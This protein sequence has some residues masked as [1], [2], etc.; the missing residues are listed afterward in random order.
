MVALPPFRRRMMNYLIRNSPYA[1]RRFAAFVVV[2]AMT[3]P[4]LAQT[5]VKRGFN[6]FSTEQE[7]EIGRESAREVERELPL[8][9][10]STVTRYVEEIGARLAREASGADY[11]YRFRVLDVADVNAFALPGGFVYVNRGLV[12]AARSE[13]E[14]AGVLAHEI[15]HVA[16]RHST[17]QISKQYLAQ[18]GLSVLGG[19]IGGDANDVLR[20]VGGAGLPLL[21]LKFGRSAEEQADT[22]GA[23]MMA[24]AGYDPLALATFFEQL[25]SQSRGGPPEFLSSHP[26]YASRRE[27][28]QREASLLA[29]ADRAPVGGFSS[30]QARLDGMREAPSMDD[31]LGE[32][33]PSSARVPESD[34]RTVGGVDLER[35]SSRWAQFTQRNQY[36]TIDYPS[37]W[38][39][40]QARDGFGVTIAP[41]NGIVTAGTGRQEVIGGVLVNHYEPF[42]GDDDRSFGSLGFRSQED[43]ERSPEALREATRD[44]LV[45]IMDGNPHLQPISDSMRSRVVDD[46]PAIA[47][48][49][50][51]TSPITGETERVTV[52]TREAGDGHVLYV[53]LVSPGNDHRELQDTF[54]RMVSSLS[55]DDRAVH[56]ASN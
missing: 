38:R 6:L 43:F 39:V 53:L 22:V 51:G 24:R 19:L 45:S 7:I 37:N 18:A 44:L 14:L 55:I 26:N 32:G 3:L 52:V 41:S 54:E 15:G 49:L 31:L 5:Q 50:T 13:A 16:L 10:D 11:P 33:R 36:Y 28:I 17:N 47:T 29:T 12:D 40:Q 42:L 1:T 27:N 46:R 20:V 25:E 21:F 2:L 35:P 34:T 4:A 30:V 9:R 48:E 23:Q 56:P 8:V